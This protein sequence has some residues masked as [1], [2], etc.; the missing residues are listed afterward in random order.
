MNI[1]APNCHGL[2]IKGIE[3]DIDEEIEKLGEMVAQ[4]VRLHLINS[5]NEYK[6]INFIGYSL[7]GIVARQ[8]LQ[9]LDRYR[10]RMN[11]FISLA[12]PHAGIRDTENPLVKTGIWFLTNFEK[13]RNLKQLNCEPSPDSH[14][15]SMYTLSQCDAISWFK[16]FV[17]VS[18]REDDFVPYQSSRIEEGNLR[19][20]TRQICLNLKLRIRRLERVEVWFDVDH[21]VGTLDK[22]TGRRAHIEFLENRVFL[23]CFFS[24]YAPLL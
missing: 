10:D 13:N 24:I 17:A 22:I 12:S 21:N 1:Y 8:A 11:L 20:I 5:L 3:D 4:E 14:L 9:H 2:L 16:K 15:I 7:G 23:D 18:S 6:R 19:D